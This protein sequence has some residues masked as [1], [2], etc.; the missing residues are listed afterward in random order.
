[1]VTG[2][3]VLGLKFQDGVLIAADTVGSY[4]SMAKYWS[5]SRIL[6]VN[7]STVMGTGGD[8]ADYQFLKNVIEQKVI[9]EEC[10]A[11]GF[12]YTPRA[13]FSWLTRVMYNRRSKMNPL[14]NTVVVGGL[15]DGQPFLGYVDKL[16]VAYEAESIASG[17]GAYIAQP[18]MRDALQKNPA[19]TE[20][21]ARDVLER[22]M[23]VLYYR[24][25]R[26]WN[27]YETAVV[28]TKGSHVDLRQPKTTWTFADMVGG[29]E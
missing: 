11:D 9:D 28:T 19:M 14:W 12:T 10:L 15:Q 2:T 25:A 13:L 26:S 23:A 3:S 27:K 8:Y 29:Y 24:D 17:Y 22:C 16:G 18:L 21:E 4:G 7:E 6:T 5:L 1:M 20:A